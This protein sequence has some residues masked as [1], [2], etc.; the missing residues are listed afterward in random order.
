MSDTTHSVTLRLPKDVLKMLDEIGIMEA[1]N[2]SGIITWACVEYIRLNYPKKFEAYI[3]QARRN[4][5][6]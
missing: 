1:R 2:R 5:A 4:K 3:E 6:K